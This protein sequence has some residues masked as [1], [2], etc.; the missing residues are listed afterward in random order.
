MTKLE[1]ARKLLAEATPGPWH[2]DQTGRLFGDAGG[3]EYEHLIRR[4]RVHCR[5]NAALIV[6]AVNEYAAL[7]DGMEA[8]KRMVDRWEPDCA[9]TDRQMWEEACAA[10]AKWEELP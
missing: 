8:L 10:L 7:L 2:S 4:D 6:A 3:G 5:S 1:Q 9:G